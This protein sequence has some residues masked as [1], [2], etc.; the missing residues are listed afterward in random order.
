MEAFIFLFCWSADVLKGK[1]KSQARKADL[2]EEK[3]FYTRPHIEAY[4]TFWSGTT[5]YPRLLFIAFISED[6][7]D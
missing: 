3:S 1:G 4:F 5:G 2:E 6:M 7:E